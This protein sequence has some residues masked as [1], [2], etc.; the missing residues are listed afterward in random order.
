M[1]GESQKY[2]EKRLVHKEPG[3]DIQHLPRPGRVPSEA[4]AAQGVGVLGNPT[5]PCRPR[6]PTPASNSRQPR[7][8]ASALW[9]AAGVCWAP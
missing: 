5:P 4:L 9:H 6:A 3:G 2:L 8:P 7:G 1:N